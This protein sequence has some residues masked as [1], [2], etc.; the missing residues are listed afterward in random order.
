[1]V[2]VLSR[3]GYCPKARRQHELLLQ[4]YRE[5]EVAACRLVTR[6]TDSITETNAYRSGVGAHWPFLSDPARKVQR[7]LDI[8]ECTDPDHNPMI[9]HTM[10]LEPGVVI[11]K[12]YNGYRFFGRPTRED[13]RHDLR[14]VTKKLAGRMGGYHNGRAQ[15]GV[16]VRPQTALSFLWQNLRP[17]PR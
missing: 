1:M 16:A 4:L 7:D 6:S 8:A 10:V 15:S 2:P 3:G 11:Y 5:P 9:P 14:A 12:I 17:H 13:L